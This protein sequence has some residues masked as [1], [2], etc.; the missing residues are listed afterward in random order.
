LV[1]FAPDVLVASTSLAVAALQETTRTLPIVFINVI[2]PVGGFAAGLAAAWRQRH[3][4]RPIRVWHQREV[5]GIAKTDRSQRDAR[6]SPLRCE[7]SWSWAVRSNPG[8][9]VA[10]RGGTDHNRPQEPA[11]RDGAN[12]TH[13][14]C[15]Q[16]RRGSLILPMPKC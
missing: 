9:R 1:E 11:A 6:R 8:H 3:R 15:Q 16:S 5:A 14:G 4:L 12:E 2:D 13:S 10:V 7:L